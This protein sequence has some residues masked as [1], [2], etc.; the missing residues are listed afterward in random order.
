MRGLHPGTSRGADYMRGFTWGLKGEEVVM[1]KLNK[2]LEGV[3]TRSMKGLIMAAAFIRNKT[4]SEEP[5][6]PVDYGNLRSSWFVAT[7]NTIVVGKGVHGF[8][9]PDA[10]EMSTNHA[11]VLSE[12]QN[13]VASQSS[14]TKMFLMMGYSVKYGG[15]VHEMVGANFNPEKRKG[16]AKRREGAGAKWLQTHIYKNT[17]KIVQI[18]KDNAQIKG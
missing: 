10:A 6:T 12:A 2:E 8:K 5:L 1:A 18:V 15:F 13:I 7:P 11:S 3:K 14:A 16:K 9:G 4:E 17:A